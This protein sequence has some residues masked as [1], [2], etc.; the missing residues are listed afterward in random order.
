MTFLK[1]LFVL[2]IHP[3]VQSFSKTFKLTFGQTPG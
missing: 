3:D 2:D 1:Q